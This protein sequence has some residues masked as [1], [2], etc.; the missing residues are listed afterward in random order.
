MNLGGSQMHI[1][2]V[3]L[4]CASK[5]HCSAIESAYAQLL[6]IRLHEWE[7]SHVS[8]WPPGCNAKMTF[9]HGICDWKVCSWYRHVAIVAGMCLSHSSGCAMVCTLGLRLS[10]KAKICTICVHLW[11]SHIYGLFVMVVTS[12]FPYIL[13][14]HKN[15]RPYV[16]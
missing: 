3:A 16:P 6:K 7:Y 10:P 5:F 9:I 2:H 14:T 12:L 11:L 8:K 1:L 15:S 4:G 13:P